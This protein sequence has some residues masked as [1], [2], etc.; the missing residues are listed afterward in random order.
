MYRFLVQLSE[1]K[2]EVPRILGWNSGFPATLEVAP[3]IAFVSE[4]PRVDRKRGQRKGATSK[5]VKNRQKVSKIFS[6]LFDNFRAAPVF[7][8]LLGGSEFWELLREC[9][10]IPSCSEN[11][12]YHSE[13]VSSCRKRRGDQSAMVRWVIWLMHSSMHSQAKARKSAG[14]LGA[15]IP[16]QCQVD[17]ITRGT[18]YVLF[19]LSAYKM[20]L[21]IQGSVNR[22]F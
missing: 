10:G 11:G 21:S 16:S 4:I 22:G 13:S 7:R 2:K 19:K 17:G 18:G 15:S 1:K 12:P 20:G 3:R 6:T 9:L 5:N 14:T 8:P